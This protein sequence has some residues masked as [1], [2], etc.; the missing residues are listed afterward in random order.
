M[1]HDLKTLAVHFEEVFQGRKTAELRRNDRNF[2]VGDTLVLR[3][4]DTDGEPAGY[5]TDA[6]VL[7]KVTHVLDFPEA[8]QPGYVMLS[9]QVLDR[10]IAG[11]IA[12]LEERPK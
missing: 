1:R 9:F 6:Y 10:G 2:Q 4:W 12:E 3:E 7:A 11:F 8:L 5:Y